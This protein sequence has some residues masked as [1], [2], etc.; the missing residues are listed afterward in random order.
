[1]LFLLI[2]IK[3][4]KIDMSKHDEIK[5]QPNVK[6]DSSSAQLFYGS[7]DSYGQASVIQRRMLRQSVD[8]L[9]KAPVERVPTKNAIRCAQYKQRKQQQVDSCPIK[10]FEM[11]KLSFHCD[12]IQMI[13]SNPFY[14]SYVNTDTSAV[15]S[16]QKGEQ[17]SDDLLRCNGRDVTKHSA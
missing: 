11:L 17:K 6:V 8:A 13:G 9:F 4:T 3:I 1:M 2:K 14:V 7:K 15:Q 12:W 5:I 10:S 16:V